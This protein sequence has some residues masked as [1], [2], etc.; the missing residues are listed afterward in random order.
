YPTKDKPLPYIQVGYFE[1]LSVSKRFENKVKNELPKEGKVSDVESAKQKILVLA[2][3]ALQRGLVKEFREM[4]EELR[5]Y[6]SKHP[7]VVAVEKVNADL[8]KALKSDDPAA[9]A[10]VKD[11]QKEGYR[12]LSSSHYT[13]L[14]NVKQL[15][16]DDLRR[17]LNKLEDVHTTFF[18]WFALKGKPRTVLGSRLVVVVVDTP[19]NN[20]KDFDTKHE[21]FNSV[22]MLDSG[23]T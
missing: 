6:D 13:L 12:T 22:P 11:L 17:K 15:G 3:W 14:T 7:V 8:K 10:L 19:H 20:K 9:Q 4:I 2:E 16:D 1:G 21:A 5:R 18:Y 23:F